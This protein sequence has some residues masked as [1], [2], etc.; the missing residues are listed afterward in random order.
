[1]V[2]FYDGRNFQ[3]AWFNNEGFTEQVSLFQNMLEEYIAYSGDSS[4]YGPF[5]KSM[6]DSNTSAD[7]TLILG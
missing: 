7:N 2:N 4:V 3:Y 1:M 5:I 6:L